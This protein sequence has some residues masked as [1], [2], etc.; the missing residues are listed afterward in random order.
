L[1]L[2]LLLR[3]VVVFFTLYPSDSK[4]YSLLLHLSRVFKLFRVKEVVISFIEA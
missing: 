1:F 3:E 4:N 2:R